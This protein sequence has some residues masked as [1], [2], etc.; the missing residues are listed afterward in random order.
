MKGD[1]GAEGFR[2]HQHHLSHPNSVRPLRQLDHCGRPRR[3]L[4]RQLGLTDGTDPLNGRWKHKPGSPRSSKWAPASTQPSSADSSKPTA[5]REAEPTT[6]TTP[7]ATQSTNLRRLYRAGGGFPV[8]TKGT[9]WEADRRSGPR[10]L[11]TGL[12]GGVSG[13]ARCRH[14]F[15]YRDHKLILGPTSE[16]DRQIVDDFLGEDS[17]SAC[18]RLCSSRVQYS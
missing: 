12:L 9:D 6:T 17:T 5:S 10:W 14:D 8:N 2:Q 1:T 15:G 18:T 4:H 7:T 16:D 3:Q 11:A 13:D